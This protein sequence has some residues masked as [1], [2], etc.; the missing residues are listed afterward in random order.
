[1]SNKV[2]P[3]VKNSD[4][5]PEIEGADPTRPRVH[6]LVVGDRHGPDG[7]KD[8]RQPP[9]ARPAPLQER[10]GY[11]DLAVPQQPAMEHGDHAPLAQEVVQGLHEQGDSDGG[12]DEDEFKHSCLQPHRGHQRRAVSQAIGLIRGALSICMDGRDKKAGKIKSFRPNHLKK[13]QR[14]I[15]EFAFL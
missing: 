11:I 7:D 10:L 8:H 9:Q 13:Q 5:N 6:D 2:E 12:D 14:V 3:P 1:M 15:G 4:K